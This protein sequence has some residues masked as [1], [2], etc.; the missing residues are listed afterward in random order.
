M[1]DGYG[2]IRAWVWRDQSSGMA[3]HDVHARE[4]WM[5][6]YLNMRREGWRVKDVTYVHGH[7]TSTVRLGC[8]W[9][10]IDP[11]GRAAR[12]TRDRQN[13]PQS[14]N[15]LRVWRTADWIVSH[16]WPPGWKLGTGVIA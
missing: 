15:V 8:G 14:R 10:L 13:V 9:F 4:G 7:Q 6:T 5:G 1:T 16:G 3:V 11:D 12:I 2:E